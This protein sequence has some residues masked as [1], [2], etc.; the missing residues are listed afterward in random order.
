[1]PGFPK[2]AKSTILGKNSGGGGAAIFGGERVFP[3][4]YPLEESQGVIVTKEKKGKISITPQSKM[5]AKLN[6]NK[7]AC[8]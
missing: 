7:I 8:R 2:I 3:S 6:M 4:L 5:G 1:M